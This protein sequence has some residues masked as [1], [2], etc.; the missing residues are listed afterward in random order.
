MSKTTNLSETEI[1]QRA[2]KFSQKHKSD[3]H[4]EGDKQTFYNDFFEI[5]GRTRR[6]VAVFEAPVKTPDGKTIFMDLFWE[7]TLLVEH[8]SLE[9]EDLNITMKNQALKYY[10]YLESERQPRY[11]LVC[12]FQTWYLL[13]KQDN[14]KYWFQLS[15]LEDNIGLFGFMTN[16]PKTI[17]AH[18]VNQEASE[19]MGCIF[20]LLKASE[21][22]GAGYF[23]TRLAFCMFADCT[24][25]FIDNRK[26][27]EYLK[28]NTS[29]DGSD[30]GIQLGYLFQLFNQHR[31]KRSKIISPKAN[32]FPYINGE[33]FAKQIELPVFNKELRDLVLK[34]G[35]YDWSKVSPAIFGNMFQTVMSK[36]QRREH[37][38]HYT[39]ED[40]I[41]KVIRPLFLD[42][43]E[44]E[45]DEIY[46]VTNNTRRERF[47]EFQNKLSSL[48]FLDP[49]CGSG[50]F[51]IL[52]YRE[53]RRLEHRVIYEIYVHDKEKPD[54]DGLSKVDV[55]Q[56]YGIEIMP[57]SAKIAEISLW[58]MDHIM[59][60]ELS[61]KYG[62]RFRRIPIKNKP[63]IVC[64]DA[65]EFDW[66]ELLSNEE[67][68]YIFGNP[69][70]SGARQMNEKQK[71]QTVRITKSADLDYVSNWF[72]KAAEY[73][74]THTHTH[75]HTHN[76]HKLRLLQ[77]IV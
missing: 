49:A 8:K 10:A 69:P 1:K 39:S 26:F 75:T 42:K 33:L 21:Y 66:N 46:E 38:A 9:K 27:L 14:S 47:I 25:V 71:K 58:M 41:L 50:N 52:A 28:D 12:D 15:E 70:F 61:S 43:L 44:E 37:G 51:L 3:S 77:L 40:N 5:F 60:L 4:E 6:T 11:I 20:E 65:L 34:A 57:F 18:P 74:P 13:D 17:E 29:N 59:N 55:D 2:R 7:K 30:M 48:K 35:E 67:C 24:G 76:V 62:F 63:N 72:V 45:F 53:I 73:I 23:L 31:D 16:R 22:A 19:M 54:S 68:S 32:A 56:F 64:A 36:E